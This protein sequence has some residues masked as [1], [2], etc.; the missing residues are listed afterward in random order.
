MD[1]ETK[2]FLDNLI[3]AVNNVNHTDWWMFSVS[4]I[5]VLASLV[6]SIMLWWATKR[7]GDRQNQLQAQQIY[8][9]L[10]RNL[11]K[12]HSFVCSSF[13]Q[14]I[15]KAISLINDKELCDRVLGQLEADFR[16]H[17]EAVM[18]DLAPVKLLLEDGRRCKDSL[19]M[20]FADM[21]TILKEMHQIIVR[22]RKGDLTI[23]PTSCLD[24]GLDIEA[25]MDAICESIV[26]SQNDV[27]YL[28]EMI[29][30]YLG[31]IKDLFHNQNA[32]MKQIEKECRIKN[33]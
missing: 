10:Y 11:D 5:S 28:K 20:L 12:L 30:I 21:E 18:D 19:N 22:Y 13:L 27:V 9:P 8:L 15:C 25:P 2:I 6:V 3:D 17:K 4:A 24:I 33:N 1:Y 26:N 23:D 31:Q 16:K 29:K 14:S 7:I 32:I